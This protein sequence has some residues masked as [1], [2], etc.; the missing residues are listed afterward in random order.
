MAKSSK[1]AEYVKNIKDLIEDDFTS[2][3]V[4]VPEYDWVYEATES[5]FLSDKVLYLCIKQQSRI[6]QEEFE[7]AK[8]AINSEIKSERSTSRIPGVDL[9]KN[10]GDYPHIVN[11][12]ITDKILKETEK[13][14]KTE[15]DFSDSQGYA[16][17]QI[18]VGLDD[19]NIVFN[20]KRLQRHTQS[21]KIINDYLEKAF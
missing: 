1:M 5:G 21:E 12:A 6:T 20:K 3:N 17:E 8:D 9:V 13:Y 7:E 2:S 4:S 19:E 16:N 10:R 11:V 15:W 14:A 18:V